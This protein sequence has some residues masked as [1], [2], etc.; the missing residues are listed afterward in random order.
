MT[1]TQPASVAR[2]LWY[3]TTDDNGRLTGDSERARNRQ[4]TGLFIYNTS[5]NAV[6]PGNGN[7]PFNV[8]QPAP[9]VLPETVCIDTTDGEIDSTCTRSTATMLN[10]NLPANRQ[11]PNASGTTQ[12]ASS[13][14]V[15]GLTGNSR[16]YH[17]VEKDL[18]IFD[19]TG[20]TCPTNVGNPRS[21]IKTFYDG[22]MSEALNPSAAA[23]TFKGTTPTLTNSITTPPT[24]KPTGA[25][26]SQIRLTANNVPAN[27]NKINVYNLIFK[28][29]IDNDSVKDAG[30]DINGNGVLDASALKNTEL[31]LA[32]SANNPD[33]TFLLR[34]PN[35]EDVTLEGLYVKLDG[36]DPNK[37]FWVFPRVGKK[38]LTIQ[39]SPEGQPTI[40]VGNFIGNMPATGLSTDAPTVANTTGLNIG[41]TSGGKGVSIRSARFL[42]FRG[43][44]AATPAEAIAED[45]PLG[46]AGIGVDS[47]AMITAMTT[48]NEPMVAPVLQIHSPL[49]T[50]TDNNAM[51]QPSTAQKNVIGLNGNVPT[52]TP[53]DGRGQWVQRASRSTVNVYFVAGN[54]PSRSYVPYGTIY[55]AESGG[56]L[57]NFVRFMENWSGR[58]LQ[59]SGGFIQNTRSV[60]A[61][62]PYSPNFPYNGLGTAGCF[63]ASNNAPNYANRNTCIDTSSGITSWFHNPAATTHALSAYFLFYQSPT[64][65]SI[66][67]FGPP[68]RLWGFDVGLLVQQP[69][70]FAQ[71]FSQ[72]RPD[73][74]EFFREA[75]KDDRWVETLLCALQP[76]VANLDTDNASTSTV[77]PGVKQRLGTVP[78]NY[79][80]Y[81]LGIKDRPSVC[82]TPT[83]NQIT[84]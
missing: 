58:Q 52:T 68:Q 20:S 64:G 80:A 74:N 30:E 71:R 76:A 65:Q 79:T 57:N 33:P 56:G 9:L 78:T 21:A 39:G 6:S 81:A 13:F 83:Y 12:P 3:R 17:A 53:T 69:D 49:A 70:L 32:A 45:L 67:Y 26:Y 41:P 14:T 42:G 51:V 28:E 47:S 5:Y 84:N 62:A 25:T 35:S 18:P 50:A 4:D 29:D 77:N 31:T 48:V 37:V 59:I 10:L 1:N 16:R 82:P 54:S 75:T 55:T 27:A 38:A 72:P 23:A 73:S 24:N 46:S 2:A 22:L 40:L 34:A 7:G 63:D 66:P 43:F 11:F 36:V 8:N 15:C 44:R 61:T 19:I 60:F